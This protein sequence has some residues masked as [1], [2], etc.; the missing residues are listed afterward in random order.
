M[1]WKLKRLRQ[2][3][4]CPWK[5]S[6]DPH[7]IPNGYSATLHQSLAGTIAENNPEG[8]L[9]AALGMAP[10]KTMACHEHPPGQEV[11]CVG[12]LMNQLGPG[13]NI[14]L[15][16]L[17]LSCENIAQVKLDGQQ[18]QRFEDTLPKSVPVGLL[19]KSD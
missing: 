4:K 13:N 9:A 6:T 15:R 3:A 11:H 14:A 17:A 8:N 12:W 5:V 1:S 7:D 19:S 16:V 2:C 10:L 18:H